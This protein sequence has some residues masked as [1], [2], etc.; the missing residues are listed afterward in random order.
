MFDADNSG[1]IDTDEFGKTLRGIGYHPS[2]AEIADCIDEADEDGSG[3]LDFL[4][5]RGGRGG[6]GGGGV[7]TMETPTQFLEIMARRIITDEEEE[8]G[9]DEMAVQQLNQAFDVFDEVSQWNDTEVAP[10]AFGFTTTVEPRGFSNTIRKPQH[11]TP[12]P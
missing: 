9:L 10:A 1:S 11:P 4:E 2:E 3:A 12:R 6:G 8:K 7:L 5:V